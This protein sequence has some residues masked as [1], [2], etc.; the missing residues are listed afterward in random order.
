MWRRDGESRETAALRVEDGVTRLHQQA[1]A[2]AAAAAAAPA[3]APVPRLRRAG[4]CQ[5]SP[6]TKDSG[7]NCKKSGQFL[8]LPLMTRK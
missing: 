4:T 2:A 6:H 1:A 7:S 3:P 5:H 8:L